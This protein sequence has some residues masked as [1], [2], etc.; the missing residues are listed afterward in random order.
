MLEF[1]MGFK[2]TVTLYCNPHTT[3]IVYMLCILM[4]YIFAKYRTTNSQQRCF[5]TTEWPLLTSQ[6]L[7]HFTHDQFSCLLVETVIAPQQPKEK[8]KHNKRKALKHAMFLSM[9][10]NGSLLALINM[11]WSDVAG[12]TFVLSRKPS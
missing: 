7:S 6:S 1:I 5:K 3:K 4:K 12:L 9:T 2:K 8:E 10:N 11:L